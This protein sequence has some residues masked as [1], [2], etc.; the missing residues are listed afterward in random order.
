MAHAKVM[1]YLVQ[2]GMADLHAY[3]LGIVVAEL[4]DIVAIDRDALRERSSVAALGG[5]GP[6]AIQAQEHRVLDLTA[7]QHLHIWI[8][9]HGHCNVAQVL[10]EPVSYTHLTMPTNREV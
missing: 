4:L 9:L 10:L 6:T 5:Q 3:I 7:C 1:R 2:H 8:I